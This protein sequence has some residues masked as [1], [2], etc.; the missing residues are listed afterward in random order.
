M[1]GMNQ[2][3][4][5][6][7]DISE[8]PLARHRRGRPINRPHHVVRGQRYMLELVMSSILINLMALALPLALLQVYRRILPNHSVDT[9]T[10]LALGV[11][12]ALMIEASL[13]QLREYIAGWIAARFEHR[14]HIEALRRLLHMP[15]ARYE[16]Q[17]SGSYVERL[18]AIDQIRD[19][20]G[21]RSLVAMVDLP[22]VLIF[23]GVMAALGGVLVLVPAG[24]MV[25]FAIVVFLSGPGMRRLVDSNT[26]LA[27]R[28]QNFMLETLRGIHGVKA[29]AAESQMIRR[30][31]RLLEQATTGRAKLSLSHAAVNSIGAMFSQMSVVLVVAGGAILAI[32]G[33]LTVGA[34]AACTLLAGR[35]IPPVQ[36]ALQVWL[37]R[38]TLRAARQRVDSLFA[39]PDPTLEEKRPPMPPVKGFITLDNIVHGQSREGHPL[40]DGVTLELQAGE[41]I[42]I[43]GGNGS[44]KS[45]LLW[46]MTGQLLP[47]DG[48]VLVDGHDLAEY[49]PRTLYRRIGFMSE[50]GELIQGTLLDNL[51]MLDPARE[52]AA[53]AAAEEVGLN[54][55]AAS[56]A[57]GYDAELG[58]KIGAA[59]PAG[60]IQRIAIARVLAMEPAVLLFD[61]ANSQLDG[62]SDR[63]V[64]E[65]LKR[66]MGRH[67]IVVISHRPSTLKLGQRHF[68]LA[69]GRLEDIGQPGPAPVTAGAA[70]R[71]GRTPSSPRLVQGEKA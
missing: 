64:M 57:Q 4:V 65:A 2:E 39:M 18:G 33:H 63:L 23:L 19:Q 67:T 22:F 31:E 46:L 48:R 16:T 36:A 26:E 56:L 49:D 55:V 70:G 25:V 14:A 11:G 61:D 68:R 35:V 15:M 38:Q 62:P 21:G 59:L 42:S 58:G 47:D 28:R 9:L 8:D 10:A 13:R 3:P 7:S 17:G 40:L 51:T 69:E 44:G 27:E 37:R 45:L 12:A 6:T 29:M 24:L 30:F 1:S 34:M 20:V 54:E 43:Q 41:C 71:A 5:R 32:Q 60:V 53:L 50:H 66:R 52:E